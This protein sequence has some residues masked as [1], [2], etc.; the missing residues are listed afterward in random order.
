MRSGVPT[1][2]SSDDRGF[3]GAPAFVACPNP[4]SSASQEL[5]LKCIGV[6]LPGDAAHPIASFDKIRPLVRQVVA[7]ELP[8]GAYPRR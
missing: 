7:E 1:L 6:V 3:I 4:A 2:P 5:L 8:P